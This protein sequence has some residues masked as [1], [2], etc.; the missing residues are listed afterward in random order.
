MDVVYWPRYPEALTVLQVERKLDQA[1]EHFNAVM[2]SQRGAEAKI[3]ITNNPARRERQ[4]ENRTHVQTVEER[5]GEVIIEVYVRGYWS[6]M[7]VI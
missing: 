2:I 6:H 1:V 7:H 5:D 3:G 4:H